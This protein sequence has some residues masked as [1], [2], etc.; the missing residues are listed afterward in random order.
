[1]REL[2]AT[3]AIEAAKYTG[4]Y[5]IRILQ[6][7]LPSNT[8]LYLSDRVC[9]PSS[10]IETLGVVK[11]WGELQLEPEIGQV[12]GYGQFTCRVT[13]LDW[14]LF[15]AE[16]QQPGIQSCR[17]TLY[18][19]FNG[20][21]WADA[22]VLFSGTMAPQD[23]QVG[24]EEVEL[25]IRG[26]EDDWNKDIG[27]RITQD[28]WPT[29]KCNECDGTIIP[30]AFGNPVYRMPACPMIQPAKST[31]SYPLGICDSIMQI[32]ES[33]ASVGFPVGE[34]IQI[35]VGGIINGVGDYDTLTGMFLEE[36]DTMFVITDRSSWHGHGQTAGIFSTAGTYWVCIDKE[37]L[38]DGG[39]K[40]MRGY[41]LIFPDL[42]PDGGNSCLVT[43][44]SDWGEPEGLDPGEICIWPDAE[45]TF[46]TSE[47]E[48]EEWIILNRLTVPYYPAGTEVVQVGSWIYP[49]NFLPIDGVDRI[50]V[51]A[52]K[53]GAPI[54]YTI[55]PYQY[56]VTE[57][58]QEFNES[59]LGREEDDPGIATLELLSSPIENGMPT[60]IIYVTMRATLPQETNPL[61]ASLDPGTAIDEPA[62]VI[63]EIASNPFLGNIQDF[64]MDLLQDAYDN[65]PI[66]LAF[67][68]LEQR[69][70]WEI[71]GDIARQSG[72]LVYVD[73]G[74]L[75][76]RRIL[77]T[78]SPADFT[79]D[80]DN[81]HEASLTMKPRDVKEMPSE[82]IGTYR[83]SMG[84]DPLVIVRRSFEA[85][86]QV[87][88]QKADDVD[89]WAIQSRTNAAYMT[90]WT[91]SHELSRNRRFEFEQF[92]EFLAA[93]PGDIVNLSHFDIGE[94]DD[95]PAEIDRVSTQGRIVSVTHVAG[96]AQTGQM[97]LIRLTIEC[98]EWEFDIYQGPEPYE[99]GTGMTTVQAPPPTVYTEEEAG[100]IPDSPK[101]WGQVITSENAERILCGDNC[102]GEPTSG[103]GSGGS[104][105][106]GGCD[107]F[108][109]GVSCEGGNV[110]GQCMT[111]DE[112]L[113]AICSALQN[114]DSALVD[115]IKTALGIA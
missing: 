69:G 108:L 15:D 96:H 36:D 58:N 55:S 28:I 101:V 110:V 27:Y 12:G 6:I 102:D 76:V 41:P 34:E 11:S 4:S 71:I 103:S 68:I 43:I 17:C 111:N 32:S 106:S 47:E 84:D 97:E 2:S 52:E 64:Q 53:D 60:D 19:W 77:Q 87:D 56:V 23:F 109:N 30:L 35:V 37:D 100:W 80:N 107:T 74:N 18:L 63:A 62:A 65:S 79:S 46:P 7:D 98:H 95:E 67:A 29:I 48:G 78:Q 13:D 49:L 26:L 88:R 3:T 40:D 10:G 112:V 16:S 1:M 73:S 8:T 82:M 24:M 33:A 59:H 44:V 83:P 99:C 9:T 115:C 105:S 90:E 45:Q 93:Q 72:L 75:V 89:L 39:A 57:N 22:L 113:S 85:Q 38:D 50:E 21:P 104:G 42:V 14:L 31:L 86:T 81:R 51:K 92:M 25:T 20:Q 61:Y 5:P 54:F 66:S 114:G 70:L 94:V 91:L